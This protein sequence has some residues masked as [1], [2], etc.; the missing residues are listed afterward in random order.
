M[1]TGSLSRMSIV[2]IASFIFTPRNITPMYKI[3]LSFL[4]I[5]LIFACGKKPDS[6]PATAAEG[7][8]I[9]K[10]YCI[11]CHGADGKLGLNGA[12]DL[13]VSAL[14]ESERIVQV[15]EGKNTMTPFKGIL[16]QD[17]IKAVV[18]YTLTL[19]K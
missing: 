3:L 12:K 9:Y 4:L 6:D 5:V 14:T 13:T 7:Q 15:T 11:L 18:A 2:S 10:Q 8:Q 19:K 1:T 16:T 17:Q